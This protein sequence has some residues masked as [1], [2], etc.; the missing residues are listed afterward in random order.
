MKCKVRFVTDLTSIL[1]V[2]A[3]LGPLKK[4][5]DLLQT[6]S[7][8]VIEIPVTMKEMLAKERERERERER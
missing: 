6:S 3:K 2:V 1:T 7:T 5:K 4:S 8:I